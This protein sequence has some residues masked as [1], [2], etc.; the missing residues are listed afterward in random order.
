MSNS[1]DKIDLDVLRRE[2]AALSFGHPLVYLETVDSTNRFLRT[3]PPEQARHGTLVLVDHQSAGRGRFD[4]Q[5]ADSPGQSL[6][7]SLLLE[8]VQ[9]PPLWPLLAL[10]AAVCVCRTLEQMEIADARIRWPNDVLIGERKVCGILI[11]NASVPTAL[12]LGVGMNV[13]QSLSD[14][15]EGLRTPAGSLRM[16]KEAAARPNAGSRKA[17]LRRGDLLIAFLR[18]FERTYGQWKAAEAAAILADCRARTATL[19]RP[20][21]LRSHGRRVEGTV[22]DLDQDG[23]LVLRE[24]TGVVSRW[25]SGDVEEMRWTDER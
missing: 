13:H 12:V 22:M 4:R 23:S 3:L 11:E 6:L 20:V 18:H 7:F 5:W 24:T 25:P 1:D 2:V 14:F 19:G 8:A 21:L 10:G 15:T 9:P 17:D 16:A